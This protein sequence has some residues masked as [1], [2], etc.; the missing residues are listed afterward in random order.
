MRGLSRVFGLLAA[1]AL[2]GVMISGCTTDSV[3]S[4]DDSTG[5]LGSTRKASGAD[6]YVNLSLAYLQD[7]DVGNALKKVKQGLEIDENH[8]KGHSVIAVIYDRLGEDDLAERHFRRSLELEPRDPYVLNAYGTFLCQRKKHAAAIEQFEAA[9]DNPL[10]ETPYV[11]LTNAGTCAKLSG[12]LAGAETYLRRALVYS[13]S[14]PGALAQMAE[15]SF[16]QENYFSCRAYLERYLSVAEPTAGMLW[17]G[18]RAEREL[19]NRGAAQMYG[20]E[21]RLKFPDSPEVQWLRESAQ[22]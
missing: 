16:L 4:E 12:D 7:G 10:Y 3:R 11:A 14:F 2:L 6:L 5:E 13:S 20:Q 17:L 19:G 22:R 15:V 9:L 8:A 21:L 1:V 18:V